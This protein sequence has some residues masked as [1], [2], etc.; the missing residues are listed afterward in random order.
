MDDNL[1]TWRSFEFG[2]LFDLLM[3]DTR[4]YDR[5]ITDMYFN[6]DYIHSISNDASRSLMGPHQENW[7]FRQLTESAERQTTWRLIGN[8]I[9]FS[10]LNLS[11]A[12]GAKN[13]MNYD[14]WDGYQASKNRT[15]DLLYRNGIS[16][17]VFLAGDSHASWVS[18]LVWLG[19]KEYDAKSGDGS[20]GV[21]FA[22]TAVSSPCP[23]GQ[24]TTMAAAL[25]ASASVTSVNPELQW[26]DIYYRGYFEL[27]IGHEAL[28]AQFFGLP[29][30]ATRNGYEIS[31]ANFTV[32]PGENR[33]HR[34][35]AGG[36]VEFG[37]LKGGEVTLGNVTHDTGSDTWFV[38]DY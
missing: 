2:D 32:F 36:K 35:V 12:L 7:F 27:E 30:Y 23:L 16:N 10:R 34:S 15:L 31:L 5:S 1:R 17:T 24:N 33:L 22:G 38:F 13:P 9:I 20:V 11:L 26:Q 28:K 25:N 29:T 3:L 21:E 14:A 37:S 4:Q 19:E 18:D 6:T 8:Q